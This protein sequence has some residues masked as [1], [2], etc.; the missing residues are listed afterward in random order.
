MITAQVVHAHRSLLATLTKCEM[1]SEKNRRLG[2]QAT[3]EM[4]NLDREVFNAF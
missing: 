2:V 1:C 3:Y 4:V